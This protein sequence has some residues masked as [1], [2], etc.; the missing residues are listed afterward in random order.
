MN[1]WA[2]DKDQS[3]R[4]L[5]LMLTTQLGA[6]AFVVDEQT[7]CDRNAVF[8]HHAEDP[9]LRAY[10]YTV[11]QQEGRYGIHLEYPPTSAAAV[12]FEANEN[13]SLEAVVESLAVH[14]DIPVIA[15]LPSR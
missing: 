15:P 13:Q 12:L 8:I 7:E 11:G 1:I 3:I 5:L 4:H 9:A 10:L 6:G 2:L 14:F